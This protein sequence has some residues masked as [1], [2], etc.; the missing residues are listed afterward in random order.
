MLTNEIKTRMLRA[1]K[2]GKTVEREILGVV[3]GDTI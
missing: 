3:L 1:L 2:A